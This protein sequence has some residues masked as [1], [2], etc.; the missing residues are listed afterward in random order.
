MLCPDISS[1]HWISGCGRRRT[2]PVFWAHGIK[3]ARGNT[4]FSGYNMELT[5]RTGRVVSQFGFQVPQLNADS[6]DR[7]MI[8]HLRK[9]AGHDVNLFS[10]VAVVGRSRSRSHMYSPRF[11]RSGGRFC[12]I[13]CYVLMRF[14]RKSMTFLIM[15]LSYALWAAMSRH[16]PQVSNIFTWILRGIF[17]LFGTFFCFL[18]QI[19][20]FSLHSPILCHFGGLS[21]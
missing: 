16:L 4:C 2:K 21:F 14:V 10:Q 8:G 9:Q 7:I 17:P 5:K 18:C 15:V 6:G 11:Q 1:K 13:A 12:P 3:K 20:S 19:E